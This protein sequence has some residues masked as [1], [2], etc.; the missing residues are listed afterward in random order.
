MNEVRVGPDERSLTLLE[1]L[2]GIRAQPR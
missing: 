1:A 2:S